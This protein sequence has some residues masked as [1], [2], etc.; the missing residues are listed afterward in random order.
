MNKRDVIAAVGFAISLHVYTQTLQLHEMRCLH[1][2]AY[3]K[4]YFLRLAGA[5]AYEQGTSIGLLKFQL[6]E[7]KTIK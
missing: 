1:S 3:N 7:F 2:T 5:G 6:L 4:F